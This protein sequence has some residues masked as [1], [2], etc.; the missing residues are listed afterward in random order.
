M[1]NDQKKRTSW[2]GIGAFLT[3]F[4]FVVVI[5]AGAALRWQALDRAFAFA[6]IGFL[7]FG[8]LVVLW[9]GWRHRGKPGRAKLGQMAALPQSWQRWVLGESKDDR[10]D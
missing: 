7:V 9:R 10:P 6:W 5:G 4:V 2:G 1:T 8:S 3:F